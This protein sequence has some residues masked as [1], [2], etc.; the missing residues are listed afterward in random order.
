M[1]NKIYREEEEKEKKPEKLPKK[2]KLRR[3][4]GNRILT[5]EN[6]NKTNHYRRQAK[7]K[8]INTKAQPFI[9]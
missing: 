5:F 1:H 2:R 6:N 8:Q 9:S 3:K 4:C 7:A